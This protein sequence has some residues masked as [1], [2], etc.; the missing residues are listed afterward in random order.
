VRRSTSS[1]KHLVVTDPPTG[2]G[3]LRHARSIPVADLIGKQRLLPAATVLLREEAAADRPGGGASEPSDPPAQDSPSSKAAK[4][5]RIAG[6]S[7]GALALCGYVAAASLITGRTQSVGAVAQVAQPSAITGA[8]ALRPDLLGAQ[9]GAPVDGRVTP[10]TMT[11]QTPESNAPPTARPSEEQ[12]GTPEGGMPQA[13]TE[14]TPQTT[15]T[16][17]ATPLATAQSDSEQPVKTEP[18]TAGRGDAEVVR[19][20]YRLIRAQPAAAFGLLDP[21]LGG[22]DRSG[23]ISSWSA[24]RAVNVERVESRPDKSIL[25]VVSLQR[26]DGSWLV[27][28]QLLRTTDTTPLRIAG[29]EILSAQLG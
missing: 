10:T 21:V 26:S 4:L 12:Q 24:V 25:A 17:Q 19:Q 1:R 28:Q 14:A 13:T 29:V 7:A 27:V 23:F 18:S 5:G 9:L 16:P 20:F 8:A 11:D 2:V 6:Y 22:S 15:Q 3:T